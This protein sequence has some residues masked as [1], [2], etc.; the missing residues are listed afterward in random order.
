MDFNLTEEQLELK[1]LARDFAQKR[2]YPYGE[3]FD[4]ESAL[5]VDLIKEAA[6]LGY[7]GF[8][9]PE[10]YGGLGLDKTAFMAVLE[11]LSGGSAA[12]GITLASH[13]SLCCETVVIFGSDE[14]KQKYL[15]AMAGGEIIGAYALSETNAGTDIKSIETTAKPESNDFIINGEK[16]Y[17]T[18]AGIADVLIVFTKTG[19]DEFTS[20]VVDKNSEGIILGELANKC[21][22]KASDTRGVTF[23]DVKV[24][25]ENVI[26]N[27]GD[28]LK[29]VKEILVGG[30]ISMA[31]QATGIAQSAF[32]EAAKYSQVRKQ[33]DQPIAN[34]QAIKFKLSEMATRIEA[35]RLLAYK[36]A[37]LKDENKPCRT[38]ASMAKLFCAETA[39]YVCDQAVQIHGGYG[40]IKEYAVERYFRDARVTEIA[41]GT[42]EA[43]RIVIAQAILKEHKIA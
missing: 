35:G 7:F 22:V 43:Q 13:A 14:L 30:R 28:G 24:P 20:F 26:G 10:E 4:E 11:E 16:A 41:D 6:E 25:K 18:N 21:G 33:F 31:I 40:Y 19:D 42:E 32:N 39:N 34:F 9:V 2:L 8:T 27:V 12:F 29:I 3:K 36:A 5:P 15:P 1:Q 38:E 23:K 17:V 37:Q